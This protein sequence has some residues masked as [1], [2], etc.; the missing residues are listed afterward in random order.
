MKPLFPFLLFL[1]FACNPE[2]KEVQSYRSEDLEITPLT[3]NSYLHLSYLDIPEHGSF[4]CNGVIYYNNGEAVV[5]DA[6]SKDSVSEVLIRWIETD[7]HCRV[8]AIV[9]NHFH[10]DCLGGLAAF[11]QKGI[12]SYANK[13][14]IALAKNNQSVVPQLGFSDSLE[15][16]VGTLK[17]VNRYFGEGHTKDNIVSY[18]PTDSLL[19]GGCLIKEVDAGFGNLEDANTK[20]WSATVSKIKTTY[21][22]LKHVV[23]G[24]GKVGGVE[25]LDYTIEKFDAN[26]AAHNA[27]TN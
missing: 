24:H 19:F 18:M 17:I 21:P 22:K 5:F 11:H 1:L 20:E 13:K 3:E 10:K 26:N 25:L 7:L 8:K 4:P 27:N 9:V 23:P 16:S 15:I 14:T 12:P 2:K 6:P